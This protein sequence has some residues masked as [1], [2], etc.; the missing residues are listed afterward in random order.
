MRSLSKECLCFSLVFALALSA[1]PQGGLDRA[2]P[3][4][5]FLN[6]TLPVETPRP[7][8]GGWRLVN[9]FPRLTFWNP[10]QMLPVPFSNRLIVLEKNGGILTIENDPDAD[11]KTYLLDI[12]AQVES[13]EDSGMVGLAFHPE[14]GLPGSPNRHYL[15]VYYRYTPDPAETQKA[16]CRLSRFTWN[17]SIGSA[18]SPSPSMN[19]FSKAC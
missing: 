2:S 16:Y 4:G 6:G 12:Q 15:Y 14:F 1:Y 13:T 7:A 18:S 19:R 3:I 11:E 9:A 5:P 8:S 17:P 10:V